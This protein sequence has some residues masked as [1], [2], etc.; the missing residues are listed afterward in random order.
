MLA[1]LLRAWADPAVQ[2]RL[3]E[4]ETQLA[5]ERSRNRVLQVEVDSLAAV[6]ARDRER[7]RAETANLMREAEG[8]SH[9]NR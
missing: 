8:G 7:V 5:E 9:G 6:V 1:W 3:K 2:G 4:I